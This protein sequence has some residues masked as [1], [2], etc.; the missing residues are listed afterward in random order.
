MGH[1]DL[2]PGLRLVFCVVVV[3]RRCEPKSGRLRFRL[4]GL[5]LVAVRLFSALPIGS[6]PVDWVDTRCCPDGNGDGRE[7]TT[8]TRFVTGMDTAGLG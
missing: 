8:V 7:Q 1:R 5:I 6:I 3:G 4:I 2:S